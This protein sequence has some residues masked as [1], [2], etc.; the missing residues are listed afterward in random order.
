VDWYPWGDEAFEKARQ[1]DKPIFLSVV[2]GW[3]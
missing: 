3:P 1:E 2:G